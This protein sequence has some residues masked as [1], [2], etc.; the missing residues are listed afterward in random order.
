MAKLS[1][2][3]DPHTLSAELVE[4]EDDH[5]T[6]AREITEAANPAENEREKSGSVLADPKVESLN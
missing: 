1:S 4:G 3:I 2:K 5:G 6:S